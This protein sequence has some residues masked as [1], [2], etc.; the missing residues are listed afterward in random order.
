MRI[1]KPGLTA[2]RKEREGK[3]TVV[4]ITEKG[5]VFC[6][7]RTIRTKGWRTETGGQKLED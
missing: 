6:Q 4:S 1:L 7:R 3:L 2:V 5:R